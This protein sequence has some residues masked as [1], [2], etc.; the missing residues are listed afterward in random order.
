MNALLNNSLEDQDAEL[1][2]G[3]DKK[4]KVSEKHDNDE[5]KGDGDGRKEDEVVEIK[6]DDDEEEEK[7]AKGGPAPDFSVDMAKDST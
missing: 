6:D 1:V 2:D 3:D 7:P 5:E 4:A